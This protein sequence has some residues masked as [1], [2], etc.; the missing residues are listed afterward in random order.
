MFRLQIKPS[1]SPKAT[2]LPDWEHNLTS[3]KPVVV[4]SLPTTSARCTRI[5]HHGSSVSF[6]AGCRKGHA[7]SLCSPEYM[8]GRH[9]CVSALTGFTIVLI[10]C[11]AH[12]THAVTLQT[13][14]QRT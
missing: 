7:D 8:S 12:A 10:F 6:S 4:G 2:L 1:T 11:F 5:H 14:L 9:R 3:C 13:V